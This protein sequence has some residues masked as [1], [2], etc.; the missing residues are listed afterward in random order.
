M[1]ILL[2]G[3]SVVDHVYRTG[4]ETKTP[5][6][7]F[8]A[9]LGMDSVKD[10]EEELFLL[11]SQDGINDE[12]FN[13][14][15]KDFRLDFVNKVEMIPHVNLYVDGTAERKE[16]YKSFVSSLDHSKINDFDEFMGIYINMVTGMDFTVDDFTE[17]RKRYKGLIY[18]DVHTLSRGVDPHSHRF[19]RKIPEWQKYVENVDIIQVNENELLTLTDETEPENI[20]E[21]IFNYN[22]QAVIVTKAEQGVKGYLEDG[23]AFEIK[24]MKV[25]SVNKIGCGDVF[26]SVFFYSYI[27]HSDFEESLTKAN[28]AAGIF[29]T[30]SNQKEMMNLRH[31]IVKRYT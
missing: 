3:H 20:L 4:E 23:K 5:G 2:A 16:H 26:G 13:N 30:Y 25:N 24:G 17:I 31:D 15:Y 10:E 6:G 11:T 29:T 28:K 19:F 18:L 9:A 12:L 1:K 7:M 14:C 21:K 8:Y 22:V 27:K